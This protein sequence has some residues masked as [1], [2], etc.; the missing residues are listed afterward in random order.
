MI[1]QAPSETRRYNTKQNT[2]GVSTLRF[3]RWWDRQDP[4]GRGWNG[5]NRNHLY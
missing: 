1:S 4:K 5:K 2:A 3:Y